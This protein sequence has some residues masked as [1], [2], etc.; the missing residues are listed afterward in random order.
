MSIELHIRTRDNLNPDPEWD[1]VLAIF[2]YIHNDWPRPPN[3]PTP[4]GCG[5]ENATKGI[6]AIDLSQP[7]SQVTTPT[8]RGGAGGGKGKGSLKTL[9][10]PRKKISSPSKILL[11]NQSKI[12]AQETLDTTDSDRRPYLDNT[13]LSSNTIRITY[14]SNERN[15]FDELMK[16]VRRVDPD[17]LLGYEIQKNSWGYLK[18]RGSHLGI[19]LIGQISRVPTA[20][21]PERGVSDKSGG[22]PSKKGAGW[23]EERHNSDI[24]VIGRVLL[25]VWRTMKQEVCVYAC[26]VSSM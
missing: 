10:S 15:L 8:K 1:P 13:G 22:S 2:Y 19:N 16:L 26:T 12:S 7:S 11:G 24:H 4:S 21:T 17:V 3:S 23:F 9:S 20:T 18:L 5:L 14:V 25:N 6:I